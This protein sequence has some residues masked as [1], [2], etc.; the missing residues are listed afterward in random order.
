MHG[1]VL[2]GDVAS[3]KYSK[4]YNIVHIDVTSRPLRQPV[5]VINIS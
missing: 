4:Q 2:H 3:G 1:L 5:A